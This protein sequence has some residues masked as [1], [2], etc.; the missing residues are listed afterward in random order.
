M[1][2]EITLYQLHVGIRNRLTIPGFFLK[3]V[4]YL[5]PIKEGTRQT[6]L[7]LL[8]EALYSYTCV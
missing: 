1:R 3:P 2:K 8:S 7:R 4:N 6:L 5:L